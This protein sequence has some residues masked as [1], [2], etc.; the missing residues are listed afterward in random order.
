VEKYGTARQATDGSVLRGMRFAC[1]VTKATD[2]YSEYVI[3]MAFPVQL[4]LHERTSM[5]RF[6]NIACLV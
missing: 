4:W 6:T 1:L 5:L 2:P 3:L